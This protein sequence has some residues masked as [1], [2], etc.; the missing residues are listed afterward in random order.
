MKNCYT[1]WL[2]LHNVCL[3]IKYI[4]LDAYDKATNLSGVS[5]DSRK[6][7]KAGYWQSEV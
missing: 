2:S 6:E 3:C 4:P 7:K 1:T 5:I